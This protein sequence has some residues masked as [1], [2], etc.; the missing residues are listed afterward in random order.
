MH[1]ADIQRCRPRVSFRWD[2]QQAFQPP[3]VK[4]LGCDRH[5]AFTSISPSESQISFWRG[6]C[7]DLRDS[8][9][10]NFIVNRQR[11]ASVFLISECAQL[12]LIKDLTLDSRRH[13][14]CAKCGDS[15]SG[16]QEDLPRYSSG[17]S[18]NR[19]QSVDLPRHAPRS[20]VRRW[21]TPPSSAF[22]CAIRRSTQPASDT[23]L[24]WSRQR[25]GGAHC[26]S[27][28]D[29]ASRDFKDAKDARKESDRLGGRWRLL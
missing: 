9:Y 28:G 20:S 15:A 6:T 14:H 17:L 12:G 25:G 18:G 29:L 2:S 5:R 4:G 7:S 13:R 26:R 22:C 21:A 1:A 24:W 16:F 27:D 11:T 19:T 10:F 23:R 8:D 3:T